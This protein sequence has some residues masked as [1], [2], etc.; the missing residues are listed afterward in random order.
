MMTLEHVMLVIH[1]VK[2]VLVELLIA[3]YHVIQLISMKILVHSLAQMDIMP[4][5]LPKLVKYVWIHVSPV[6]MITNV[7]LVKVKDTYMI[8]NVVTA[9]NIT[10][11]KTLII[12]VMHVTLLVLLVKEPEKHNVTLV[13]LTTTTNSHQPENVSV[14][15]WK[16]CLE[17]VSQ[18][19]V[20]YVGKI[21]VNV[22]K[23]LLMVSLKPTVLYVLEIYSLTKVTIVLLIVQLELI[24]SLLHQLPVLIV[25]ILVKN[26][27]LKKFVLYV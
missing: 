20:T 18:E 10:M 24:Q 9:Q 26:V 25:N 22:L 17:T 21:V 3:V 6:S 16:E 2:P 13:K 4:P 11:L 1:L 14:N 12:H 8:T 19:F 15:V 27:H 5:L 23:P 7:Q